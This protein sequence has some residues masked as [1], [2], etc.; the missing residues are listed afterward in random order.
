[1][2]QLRIYRNPEKHIAS[3]VELPIA[4]KGYISLYFVRYSEF[5]IARNESILVILSFYQEV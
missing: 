3:T 4:T 5:E 2:G 1:M